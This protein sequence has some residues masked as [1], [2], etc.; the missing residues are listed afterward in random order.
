[1]TTSTALEYLFHYLFA[2]SSYDISHTPFKFQQ[3]CNK[4]FIE[5]FNKGQ[6]KFQQFSLFSILAHA[7]KEKQN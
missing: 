7:E 4:H 3:T 2:V 1:M 5:N 6:G